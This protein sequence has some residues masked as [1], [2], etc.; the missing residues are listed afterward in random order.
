MAD[1]NRQPAATDDTGPEQHSS[2]VGEHAGV[3]GHD[4]P[5]ET[6]DTEL[7]PDLFATSDRP[8]QDPD[9]P[10]LVNGALST[11]NE[12]DQSRITAIRE[13]FSKCW[14]EGPSEPNIEAHVA[15][16][17]GDEMRKRL[18]HE[19][20]LVD[21]QH[22]SRLGKPLSLDQYI[23]RLPE[24]RVEIEL[25]FAQL[26]STRPA[27]DAR[28]KGDDRSRKTIP[29]RH[30]GDPSSRYQPVDYHARGGLGVVY[31][32]VDGELDRKVAL[33]EILPQHCEEP[34]YQEKFVFEA[35]VTGSLEHP[36]IVPVYGLGR[37]ED[38][39]PYYAMRF[40]EGTSLRDAIRNFHQSHRRL[41]NSDFFGTEF[42]ALLRRLIDT[43]NAIH[44][45]NDRGVVHRDIKPANIMLGHYGETLVVDW[46]LAKLVQQDSAG[47][48]NSLPKLKLSG[49]GVEAGGA[50]VGTPMY[51]SPEQARGESKRLD[52]R[53]DVYSLGAM[54][55]NIV[56][57]RQ[58]ISGKTTGEVLEN[59]R[60]GRIMPLNTSVPK[61]PR[62]LNSICR[63]AMALDPSHRYRTALELADDIDR[64]ANGEQ[65]HAHIPYETLV[66]RLTRLVRKHSNWVVPAAL[67]LVVLS[68]VAS[69]A[70]ILIN[71]AKNEA[72]AYKA[73][74]V[75]RYQDSRQAIKTW[76]YESA[77][78]LE[79]LPGAVG[80][81]ERLLEV[82]AED[83][84]RLSERESEDPELELERGKTLVDLGRL[85]LIQKHSDLA[86]DVFGDALT[87]LEVDVAD[88]RL[89]VQYQS[90]AGLA[91]SLIALSHAEKKESQK[92]SRQYGIATDLLTQLADRS[93]DPL[94]RQSLA[95]T[96]V[97]HAL[98]LQ[99]L[100]N[101]EDAIRNLL[102]ALKLYQSLPA[103]QRDVIV[104]QA[105]AS[106]LLGNLY[107]DRG[108]YALGSVQL[109]SAI[110]ELSKNVADHPDQPA[111]V[112]L[113]ASAYMSRARNFQVRGM[114]TQQLEMLRL[115]LPH[116][117]ELLRVIPDYPRYKENLAINLRNIGVTQHEMGVCREAEV[118]TK[119]SI[120]LFDELVATY[121][122]AASFQIHLASCSLA[123]GIILAELQEDPDESISLLELSMSVFAN[124][125]KDV[126][127]TEIYAEKMVLARSH[128]ADALSRRDE[129][130]VADFELA[131]SQFE[132][133]IDEYGE[134]PTYQHALAE[135][136]FRYANRLS[137]AG[138]SDEARTHFEAARN[139]WSRIQQG[140]SAR[141]DFQLARLLATCPIPELRDL[142]AARGHID[143]AIQQVPDNPE[144][145]S[146]LALI[147]SLERRP[148]KAVELLDRVKSLRGHWID[149][150][151]FVLSVVQRAAGDAGDA[152]DADESLD[153]GIQWMKDNR[154]FNLQSD[155]LR[156]MAE[157]R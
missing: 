77:D 46:G 146:I 52:R 18:A 38:K 109:D 133:L 5:F 45:A 12:A 112:N 14:I 114:L 96:H 51:M 94:P 59:V 28:R 149:R 73:E 136:H 61:A 83:Y 116:H 27:G 7:P 63:K 40:I 137:R 74:A 127:Y 98:L 15:V 55:F 151:F 68:I 111:Y 67:A 99:E 105:R 156:E 31:V 33:K 134:K 50:A 152:D 122:A 139:R 93:D 108:D 30:A 124:L 130:A 9:S 144:F 23:S 71:R 42:R 76:L 60:A 91:H 157:S 100:G 17:L 37:Y 6:I 82:A 57:G 138:K 62:A 36:G 107:T 78:T 11:L 85:H 88:P 64:W 47:G 90:Y 4:D 10:G 106:E 79:F 103:T 145:V 143:S 147:E 128:Y 142:N 54:F 135:T 25:A 2:P 70:A 89:R 69:I 113:L 22:R 84:S 56:S 19:L 132:Q 13:Q 35:Q 43:C 95:L 118:S 125:A 3:P 140:R 102:E 110:D 92:A 115:A 153:R 154:P 53:S 123:R 81:R 48:K 39:Q 86:I 80:V 119:E 34:R 58:P 155:L 66:E 120:E 126:L 32:A 131:I 24:F 141:T 101:E 150:D 129:V 1:S 20:V 41:S 72:K 29:V 104:G 87:V 26:S 21:V 65:V 148:A 8:P 117:R 121:G 49:S 44:Y 16:E 75:D 97:N